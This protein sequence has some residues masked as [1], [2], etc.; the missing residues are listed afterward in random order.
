ML[1]LRVLVPVV[2]LGFMPIF[3]FSSCRAFAAGNEA[4]QSAQGGA[5]VENTLPMWEAP[6]L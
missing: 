2:V 5:G 1:R 6:R 3:A 4:A